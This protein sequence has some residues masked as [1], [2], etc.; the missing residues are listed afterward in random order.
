MVIEYANRR[1]ISQFDPDGRKAGQSFELYIQLRIPTSCEYSGAR[2]GN[3]WGC[4]FLE[5]S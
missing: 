1:S 3:D 4:M 5:H 2:K